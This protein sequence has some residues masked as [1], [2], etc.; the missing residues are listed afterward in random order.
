MLVH[1][2]VTPTI[3]DTNTHPYTWVEGGIMKETCLVQE[4][5]TVSPDRVQTLTAWYEFEYTSP[6]VT[7]PPATNRGGEEILI[8]MLQAAES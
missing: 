4:H 5:N 8:Y 3:K 2:R 6:N 7:T 1:H